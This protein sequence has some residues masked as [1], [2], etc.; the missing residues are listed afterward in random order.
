M[1]ERKRG[2]L[3]TIFLVLQ[4]IG[5]FYGMFVYYT[6]KWAYNMA[7]SNSLLADTYQVL[8]NT[9]VVINTIISLITLIAIVG[10]FRWYSGS[11]YLY[12]IINAISSITGIMFQPSASII[13][14]YIVK[15]IIVVA[16]AKSLLDKIKTQ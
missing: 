14:S 3:I 8:S 10:V 4:G 16:I 7:K 9:E 15:M 2:I 1:K 12:V 11:I 5:A 13:V 6:N